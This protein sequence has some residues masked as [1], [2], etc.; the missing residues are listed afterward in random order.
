MK[1]KLILS[2]IALC[3][4]GS[5][6]AQNWPVTPTLL[7]DVAPGSTDGVKGMLCSTPVGGKLVF[8]ADSQ[9]IV[10]KLW[11]TDGTPA[12]TSGVAGP[13]Y[14]GIVGPYMDFI[15]WDGKV[16]HGGAFK[17]S[18]GPMVLYRTGLNGNTLDSLSIFR[19]SG[20]LP[21]YDTSGPMLYFLNEMNI[22][23]IEVLQTDGSRAG[24]T[25]IPTAFPPAAGRPFKVVG[26]DLYYT[27]NNSL[28]Y[29]TNVPTGVHTKLSAQSQSGA[30]IVGHA[31]S[32]VYYT[33]D[34]GAN[35]DLWATN[36]TPA[37]TQLLGAGLK[38][39]PNAFKAWKGK[40]YF[41]VRL[42]TDGVDQNL[43]SSDGTPG[44]TTL[45]FSLQTA[46]KTPGSP[47]PFVGEELVDMG[48]YMLF[49]GRDTAGTE[50]WR[51]DGTTAGTYRVKDLQ[52]RFSGSNSGSIFE[53][54]FYQSNVID[55]RLYFRAGSD[56][57]Q[58]QLHVTDGTSAG[59][60]RAAYM[61]PKGQNAVVDNPNVVKFNGQ[62][63]FIGLTA[64]YG[65]EIYSFPAPPAITTAVVQVSTSEAVGCFP[66]PVSETLNF[67]GLQ[68]GDG[69][70]ITDAMGRKI[71]SQKWN[72]NAVAVQS[73][74]AGLYLVEV[75]RAGKPIAYLKVVRE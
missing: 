33:V 4:A 23:N 9:N 46:A 58:Y 53:N 40:A 55:G 64:A 47:A 5:A 7:R 37:G 1:A 73:W 35:F 45:I 26:N 17:Y 48:D 32:I 3:L 56:T 18:T 69:L 12:G 21:Q 42:A 14:N 50:P 49:A 8:S 10:Q 62:I 67:T 29:K 61:T 68:M 57:A 63:Y 19:V 74:P 38:K 39:R 75:Q 11:A 43:W 15:A 25:I 44:G 71:V 60:V 41:G 36:G 6:T 65:Q 28:I 72:G 30:H 54:T 66:N 20:E 2:G 51:T 16:A 34:N 24:T 13:L 52:P 27:V 70:F 31:A 59:T 22:N